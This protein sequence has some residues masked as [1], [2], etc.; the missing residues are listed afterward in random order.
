M[1]KS[2][3]P[4]KAYP[5]HFTSTRGQM[6]VA[7][8]LKSL[9]AGPLRSA[10]IAK[11]VFCDVS[12][13]LAVIKHLKAEP[14]R[15]FI[16]DYPVID[17]QKVPLYAL[18]SEPDAV[19]T[20][21]TKQEHYAI[22]RADPEKHAKTL[23][24]DRARRRAARAALP[25]SEKLRDRRVYDP[26]LDQQILTLLEVPGYTMSQMAAK[27]DANPRSIQTA[28]RKLRKEGKAQR[29][30]NGTKKEWQWELCTRPLPAPIV[31]VRKPQGI[32]AALGL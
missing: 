27:L 10:E 30:A 13:V 26:P 21:R 15:V 18:G 28:I 11:L 23:A 20:R 8:V 32:F 29:A 3:R 9:E 24:Q 22:R 17:G 7:R 12:L 14:Q 4:R 5:Y 16:F 6:R 31:S 25:A 2:T 1:G 19:R